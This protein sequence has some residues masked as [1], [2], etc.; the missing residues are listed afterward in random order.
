MV[1][2]TLAASGIS[3]LTAFLAKAGQPIADKAGQAF[4]DAAQ[5]LFAT[6]KNKFKGNSY[7]EQALDR[8]EQ[9][10]ESK[11]RQASVK[12][13]LLEQMEKDDVF[14]AEVRKLLDVAQKADKN[15]VIA[16]GARSIAIGGNA[17]NSIIITGDN[18]QLQ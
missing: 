5:S 11:D 14:A 7:A 2:E 9:K 4:A 1:M 15:G 17:Q 6:I 18:N 8:L 13:A 12:D 3:M 10:P 16:W